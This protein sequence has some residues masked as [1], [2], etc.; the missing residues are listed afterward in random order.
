M[1]LRP[2]PMGGREPSRAGTREPIVS[3]VGSALGLEQHVLQDRCRNR[4]TA[5]EPRDRTGAPSS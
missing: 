3:S 4:G 1:V 2:M 5:W